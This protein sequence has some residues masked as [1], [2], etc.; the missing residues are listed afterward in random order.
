MVRSSGLFCSR[1]GG[2]EL[3]I[4]DYLRD[5]LRSFDSF[6]RDLKTF[7]FSLYWRTQRDRGFAIMRYINLPFTLMLP[8]LGLRSSSISSRAAATAGTNA[9]TAQSSD[10]I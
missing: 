6:R 10:A 9:G 2:L 1:P 5:P 3:V 4:P 7:L 8:S